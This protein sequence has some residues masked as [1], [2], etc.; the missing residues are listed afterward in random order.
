MSGTAEGRFVC[1]GEMLLRLAAP[2]RGALLH[3]PRLDAHFGGAEANVAAGLARL[4][5]RSA[6]VSCVPDDAIGDA[7]LESLRRCG[8]DVTEVQRARGRLG[9][10]YLAPGAGLRAA[11]IIYDRAHSVFAGASAG[12]FDWDRLLAGAGWLHMSGITPA[13]G[14]AMATLAL[15]AARAA[16]AMGVRLSFDGNYRGQ[17]W[18][19]WASEPR[20]ILC[21]LV[22]EADLLFGNHRD[23]SLLLGESFDGA[24]P[25]RRREAALAA[26]DAF[27]NLRWI[28]STARH[29][30]DAERNGFAARLDGRDEAWQTEEVQVGGIIDRIGTGD[31]FAAGV[32]HGLDLGDPRLAVDTGF[33]LGVLK[34]YTA[35]DMSLATLGEV[36]AFL[37]G[38]RD[39]RR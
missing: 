13:L 38:E 27:P 12:R 2:S 10:Y 30:V 21:Q 1:F 22:G 17:L 14:P 16:R 39:V 19:A 7:A 28:A 37:A 9:L 36:A 33:A 6:M 18:S 35:G 5:R 8:V 25:A 32:L 23:L 24:G 11:A 15:E 34:H 29:V 4:G 26:F 31:A 3:E 20:K